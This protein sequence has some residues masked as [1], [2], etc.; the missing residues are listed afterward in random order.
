MKIFFTK[1]FLILVTASFISTNSFAQ[2]AAHIIRKTPIAKGGPEKPTETLP[3]KINRNIELNAGPLLILQDPALKACAVDAGPHIESSWNLEAYNLRLA[4]IYEDLAEKIKNKKDMSD[5]EFKELLEF[6]L[7]DA[8]RA[9]LYLIGESSSAAGQ[10][11]RAESERMLA[12]FALKLTM[13]QI[14]DPIHS[15]ELY[16]KA[17]DHL[18]NS[19]KQLH[20]ISDDSRSTDYPAVLGMFA[21]T[22]LNFLQARHVRPALGSLTPS[23]FFTESQKIFTDSR[24]HS[25]RASEISDL[26]LLEIEYLLSGSKREIGALNSQIS[27][28]EQR[29]LKSLMNKIPAQEARLIA[30][31][32]PEEFIKNLL[33]RSKILEQIAP[34]YFD[35]NKGIN[36]GFEALEA[37]LASADESTRFRAKKSMDFLGREQMGTHVGFRMQKL[38]AQEKLKHPDYATSKIDSA[39]EELRANYNASLKENIGFEFIDQFKIPNFTELESSQGSLLIAFKDFSKK[40][41]EYAQLELKIRQEK[42]KPTSEEREQIE[43]LTESIDISWAYMQCYR[44]A[45]YPQNQRAMAELKSPFGMM[46]TD[47]SSCRGNSDAK[48]TQIAHDLVEKKVNSGYRKDLTWIFGNFGFDV[49]TVIASGG[50]SIVAKKAITMTASRALG[51]AALRSGLSKSGAKAV[52]GATR[53]V[54]GTAAT[55]ASVQVAMGARGFVQSGVQNGDWHF[56]NFKQNV[57]YLDPE[58]WTMAGASKNIMRIAAV[59]LA[60]GAVNKLWKRGAESAF[61]A[62]SKF[63]QKN[64]GESWTTEYAT[65]AVKGT[66]S[67]KFKGFAKALAEAPFDTTDATDLKS[68]VDKSVSV[69]GWFESLQSAITGKLQGNLGKQMGGGFASRLTGVKGGISG[70]LGRLQQLSTCFGSAPSPAK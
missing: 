63:I 17:Q 44:V 39:R 68:Q 11:V 22:Q 4:G 67:L 34:F 54:V 12:E 21:E 5:L 47:Y 29:R 28:E 43:R 37:N 33:D 66:V 65:E 61:I 16:I 70:N 40:I 62:N 51:A 25:V 24:A 23:E 56:E 42:R 60:G 19:L 64:F 13:A 30:S 10:I 27:S 48:A 55:D 50:L 32:D 35:G 49:I 31:K 52:M 9:Q 38:A 53:V 15:K 57:I 58:S 46:S 6:A 2:A 1:R 18:S 14:T 3:P 36:R 20:K 8:E 69:D 41:T 45:A 26:D 7:M 59:G